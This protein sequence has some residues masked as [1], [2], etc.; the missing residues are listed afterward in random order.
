LLKS[1][2]HRD[3]GSE[4]GRQWAFDWTYVSWGDR[5]R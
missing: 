2:R 4:G 5:G 1:W 3:G